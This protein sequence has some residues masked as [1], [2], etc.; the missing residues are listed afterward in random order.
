MSV[1]SR[2]SLI[3]VAAFAV[4]LALA[5]WLQIHGYL[6]SGVVDL[7]SRVI[8]Q[9][10]GPPDF[11]PPDPIYPPL[12]LV[13]VMMSHL[14]FGSG[15][16]PL[17]IAVAAAIAALMAASWFSNFRS[18]GRMSVKFAGILTLLLATHPALLFTVSQ[19]PELVLLCLGVWVFTRGMV[20]LRQSGNAPDMMKV[21]VGLMLVG[22][23]SAFGLLFT[24]ATVPFLAVAAR[25][26]LFLSSPTGY[27]FAIVFPIACAVGS[28]LFVSFIFDMPLVAEPK[29]THQSTFLLSVLAPVLTLSLP[30]LAS[31]FRMRHAPTRLVPLLASASCVVVAAIFN[32]YLVGF[33]DPMTACTPLVAV[34]AVAIG[35]WPPGLSRSNFGTSSLVASWLAS[36]VLLGQ[37][38]GTESDRWQAHVR[39]FYSAPNLSMLSV[40]EMLRGRE[41]I[42][43]D[44][45]RSPD[46]VVE[47]GGTKGMVV[48][49]TPSFE[50]TVIG[51][52][53][54]ES[55]I[56]ARRST[57]SA[58]TEDQ[59]LRRF[60]SISVEPPHGYIYRLL[61]DEW[62][63]L[64]RVEA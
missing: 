16:V 3:W 37:A 45:E 23:S 33:A 17:P 58:V 54:D 47:L 22:L 14:V 13:L 42:L 8:V 20:H 27:L 60:P 61:S 2:I 35:F 18:Q 56:V 4:Y 11:K 21:A 6:A 26:S 62:I 52:R 38:E 36:A 63:V 25:P 57:N 43:I 55:F 29:S 59:V 46:L 1:V 39:G 7:W 15:N 48:A 49:G 10:D 19:G 41:G 64:E 28:L 30:I 12:P 5:A 40:A 53:L 50:Q 34:A 9:I 32:Y 24:L 31:C 44:V 51:G